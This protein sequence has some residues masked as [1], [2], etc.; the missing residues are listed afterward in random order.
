M[1]LC[2]FIC[3]QF[4][5]HYRQ[6][7]YYFLLAGGVKRNLRN[8]IIN[9]PNNMMEMAQKPSTLNN[10]EAFV[11]YL[12]DL[13]LAND[14]TEIMNLFK[15]NDSE[16]GPLVDKNKLCHPL[17][18]C[19]KC[20]KSR[21]EFQPNI[22]ERNSN[23]IAAIHLAAMKGLPK[24]LTLIL[25]LKP[26]INAVDEKNWTALHYAAANGHQNLLLLLLHA[27]ININKKADDQHTSLHL[28][29]LN[30]H[31]GCVKALLYF[32]EHMRIK[33]EINAQTS[34]GNT[35]NY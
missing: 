13:V 4:L 6:V 7:I 18:V 3:L 10:S 27:G 12:F 16:N 25:T 14:E 32:A 19:V 33:V 35:G 30:G 31:S 34:L 28:A 20:K 8:Q 26:D 29:S 22:N 21:L 24:M 11:N 9:E 1:T 2:Y 15:I 23:G 17:C 5:L